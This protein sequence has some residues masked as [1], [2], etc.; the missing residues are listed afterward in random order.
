M[1]DQSLSVQ[2]G[3]QAGYQVSLRKRRHLSDRS[4]KWI[5]ILPTLILFV[6]FGTFPLFWS[7]VLSFTKYNVNLDLSPVFVGFSNYAILLGSAAVWGRFVIT[8]KFVAMAVF[9][10]FVLGFGIAL[11]LNRK[12]RGRGLITILF[13]T[14][15]MLSPVVVGLFWRFIFEPG[16]GILNWSLMSTF[17]VPAMDWF[18]KADTAL[19]AIVIV[20]TWM[21]TPFMILICLAGLGSIP[22]YLYEAAA[23]DRAST[24]FKFRYITLPIV[25][26]LLLIA[27]LFRT[28][29]AFKLF[30]FV[31]V[32][33]SGG[34]G[35]STESVSFYLYRE[36]FQ[37]Y[38]TGT[39]TALAFILLIIIVALSNVY[40]RYLVKAQQT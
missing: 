39:S 16:W 26:P 2:A 4:L 17:H 28:M 1:S 15:M 29:D 34:P 32:L 40:I 12:F 13:L 23:V 18:S 8:I 24:W 6:S 7:L 36:A 35:N 3:N 9:S 10:E 11:L 5:L 21:W 19:Y 14:P 33:S 37:R 25:S 20:D 27:L 38:N 22:Q 31:W 30:D